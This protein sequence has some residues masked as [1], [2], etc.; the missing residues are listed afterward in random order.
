VRPRGSG[1][2]RRRFWLSPGGALKLLLA[3]AAGLY[4]AWWVVRTSVVGVF[5]QDN[6]FIAARADPGHPRVRLE[7][8][9]DDFEVRG[10]R[11]RPADQ[12]AALHALGDAPLATEPFFLA[13]VAALAH[14]DN[15]DGDRLLSEARRRDP[16]FR[17][18]RLLLLDRYLIEGRTAEAVSEM[19][20]LN[21]LIGGAEQ[22]I[23]PELARLALDPR[24]S[25]SLIPMLRREPQLQEA[26]LERL[27]DSGAKPELIVQIASD[28]GTLRGGE[29]LWQDKMLS[30]M[31]KA[32]DLGPALLLWRR[33]AGIGE[34]GETKGLYDGRFQGL[35]GPR[36]FNWDLSNGPA[37]VADRVRNIGLQ[38][39]YYGRQDGELASQLLM[40]A[41]GRY[42]MQFEADGD[43]TGQNSRLVWMISCQSGL[44]LLQWPVTGVASSPRRF[45]TSFAIPAGC[46]A[47]WLKLHGSSGD[48]AADQS[49]NFKNMAIMPEPGR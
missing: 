18:A 40:L 34:N 17:M 24:T 38:V 43:A 19:A 32:G 33:F 27:A 7:L 10:G 23:T 30:N 49:A 44:S 5:V 29:R 36:P 31:V 4:L 28:G 14:G 12:E 13:G 21:R 8:A 20:A 45:S 2:S 39:D 25:A 47:Q 26:I 46:P 16:R 42:R 41:P 15:E 35:P 22:V 48:V 11:V 9:L 3:L 6:P 37:G 1:R